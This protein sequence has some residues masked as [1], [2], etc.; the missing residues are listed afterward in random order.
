VVEPD[1][2]LLCSLDSEGRADVK[3]CDLIIGNT[4]GGYDY[5]YFQ[6]TQALSGTGQVIFEE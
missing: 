5:V 2:D 1:R 4:V 6:G 3:Q